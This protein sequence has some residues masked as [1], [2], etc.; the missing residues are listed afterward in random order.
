MR[1]MVSPWLSTM[2]GTVS[3][4][5]PPRIKN[6]SRSNWKGREGRHSLGGLWRNWGSNRFLR[7]HRRPRAGLKD[8]GALSRIGWSNELRLDKVDTLLAANDYLKHSSWHITYGLPFRLPNRAELIASRM[9]DLYPMRCSASNTGV[10][11]AKTMSFGLTIS[12]FQILPSNGRSSYAHARVD[13]HEHMDGSL[14]IYYQGKCLLTTH[15]PSEAPI[16]RTRTRTSTD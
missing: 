16:L 1:H 3:L 4:N 11:W 10:P 9:R 6:Q 7:C 8:Y 2:T 13:V 15:A 14:A 12:G 5:V